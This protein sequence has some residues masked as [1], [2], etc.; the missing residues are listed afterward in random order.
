MKNPLGPGKRFFTRFF[1]NKIMN[2]F[3][4]MHIRNFWYKMLGCKISN[5]T[6]I[7]MGCYFIAI[8]NI[9]IGN[10]THIN[11]SC[12]IDGR[13]GIKIGN[14]V[15]ISHYV[16]LCTGGHEIN[17]PDFHDEYLPIEID[18]YA[19]IG[20]GAIILKNVKI[21]KGAVVAAGSVVT[22]NVESY[23]I[24]GGVPA[25]KIGERNKNLDYTCLLGG[26]SLSFY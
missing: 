22:K 15:S 24:V 6:Y 12:F 7:D 8:Q 19:W 16:K 23:S 13:G 4:S 17:S 18:D 25:K 5:K 11:Q 2:N 21:G 1:T 20:I 14:N 10:N 3:P 26:R 9:E